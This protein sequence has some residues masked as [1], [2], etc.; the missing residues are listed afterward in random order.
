M[1]ANPNKE[2]R[3]IPIVE[4]VLVK[5]DMFIFSVDFIVLDMKEDKEVL[6]IL[7]DFFYALLECSLMWRKE[8]LP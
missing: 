6:I 1:Q 7:G 4:E 3:L 2:C 8:S 5:V